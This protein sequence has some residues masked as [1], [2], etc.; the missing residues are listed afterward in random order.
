MSTN[1][2]PN[3]ALEPTAAPF[4][5]FTVT[6]IRTRIVRSTVLV[7]GCGSALVRSAADGARVAKINSGHKLGPDLRATN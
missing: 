2:T 6:G 5:R 7:T 4:L 3:T 1:Q